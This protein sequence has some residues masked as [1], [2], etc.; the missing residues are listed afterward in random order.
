MNTDLEATNHINQ[1]FPNDIESRRK[2]FRLK[3]FANEYDLDIFNEAD[4][5]L[6][7]CDSQEK[8]LLLVGDLIDMCQ[9][10]PSVFI[11]L[12]RLQPSGTESSANDREH[13]SFYHEIIEYL[14]PKWYQLFKYERQRR[15]ITSLSVPYDRSYPM[16]RHPLHTYENLLTVS[17]DS[18]LQGSFKKKNKKIES[19]FFDKVQCQNQVIVRQ[20]LTP[21]L[22]HRLKVHVFV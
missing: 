2:L 9:E 6:T 8:V 18:H 13:I 12:Y 14:P 11:D 1:R 17:N 4:C 10:I 16:R 21:T 22:R 5:N 20:Q 7:S 19:D 3:T 15:H